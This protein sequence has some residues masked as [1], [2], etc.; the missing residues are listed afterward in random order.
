MFKY[1]YPK[2]ID[3][4]I[5][6][7]TEILFIYLL[8]GKTCKEIPENASYPELLKL[9]SDIEINPINNY[10]DYVIGKRIK[11]S[12][13]K[14]YAYIPND[15]YCPVCLSDESQEVK[16]QDASFSYEYGSEKGINKLIE[17]TLVC[18]VC[19]S[20]KEREDSEKVSDRIWYLLQI[21]DGAL[22]SFLI[23]CKECQ[24]PS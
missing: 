12:L 20:E 23:S 10:A 19:G 5:A 13:S 24:L 3:L 17:E 14:I 15:P 16:K 1:S 9:I 22:A 7:Y 4:Y 8:Q 18:P 6:T 11:E 2:A 21:L